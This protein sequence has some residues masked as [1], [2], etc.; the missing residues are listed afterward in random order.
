MRKGERMSCDECDKIQEILVSSHQENGVG[1][2]YIRV[3]NANMLIVGCQEHQ[4]ILIELL[5][6]VKE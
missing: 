5:R 2:C 4:K 3:G 6:K 1:L